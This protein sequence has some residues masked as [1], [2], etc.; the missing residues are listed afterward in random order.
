MEEIH[1]IRFVNHI[2]S[3]LADSFGAKHL[4]VSEKNVHIIPAD[5]W[6]DNEADGIFAIYEQAVLMRGTKSRIAFIHQLIHEILHFKS[7]GSLIAAAHHTDEK[8]KKLLYRHSRLGLRIRA[9]S[10]K[11]LFTLLNEAVTE[12]LAIRL[13][14]QHNIKKLYPQE[15]SQ[16]EKIIRE[17][18]NPEND[19]VIYAEERAGKLSGYMFGYPRSRKALNV[20][21]DKLYERNK[22][23]YKDR[24]EIF[25]LFA[26][27]MF[28][29][30][31]LNLRNLI[32]KTFGLG[33]FVKLGQSSDAEFPDEKSAEELEYLIASL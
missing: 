5:V 19:E 15:T 14:Q 29:G 32:D 16:T 13:F 18:P 28:S 21:I 4:D 10:R 22:S 6:S 26:R 27:G 3:E 8:K 24:K 20:L 11:F 12:E 17:N 23:T 25:A 7:Y 31:I 1:I 2:T 9:R 30:K 33:T